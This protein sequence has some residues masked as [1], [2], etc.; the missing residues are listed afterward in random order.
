MQQQWPILYYK[1]GKK[2]Y[3]TLHMWTQIVGKIKLATLP[4]VNHSWHITLHITPT[5]L[6]TQ[7]MPFNNKNF[8]IDFDFIDHQLKVYTSAGELR[9]F[10][11]HGVS[12]AEFYRKIF[13]LLQQLE[14]DINIKPVPVEIANPIPF[15]KDTVHFT[16]D[17]KQVTAFHQALLKIQDV[18]MKFR[19]QFKGKC[20]PIHFFW[21]SFDVALS[22]FSGR[23]APKH[24]G[25]VPGLPNWVA[26]E[27]YCREV[28]S[29]GFWT[30]NDSLPE[31]AFYC[32][33]YPEPEAY[34]S[35]KV[36]PQEAYYRPELREFI[37][38]YSAVQQSGDAEKTLLD[39]LQSTYSLGADLANGTG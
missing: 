36:L 9:R 37:L 22:F 3:D 27:A 19:S 7:V 11:L 2:T 25:G 1:E 23:R 39:F 18:F 6:T 10:D 28:S 30:G 24:P 13:E 4:W 16:Y 38:P 35:G 15:E 32:Y 5:G 26:E 14:I 33:M 34:S 29:C 21:G 20:S 12:V 17:E 31:P 8:T